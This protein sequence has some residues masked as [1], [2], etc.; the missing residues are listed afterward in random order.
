MCVDFMH[1]LK[2]KNQVQFRGVWKSLCVRV[3]V[4]IVL[5]VLLGSGRKFDL[6]Y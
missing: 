1:F 5:G 2:M 6:E 4:L 3:C